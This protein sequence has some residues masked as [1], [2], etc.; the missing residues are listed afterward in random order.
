MKTRYFFLII[1]VAAG[2][3]LSACASSNPPAATQEPQP[4]AVPTEAPTAEP[5]QAPT[6]APEEAPAASADG[7][8]RDDFEQQLDP[9]WTWINEDPS[10]WTIEAGNLQIT[11]ADPPIAPETPEIPMIN[12]LTRPIPQGVD[13]AV[14][15]LLL[16]TNPDENFEQASLLLLDDGDSFV[17]LN[18]GF[19]SFCTQKSIY[20]ETAADG[21]PL[22]EGMQSLP[23]PEDA[24]Q[25]WLRLEYSPEAKVVVATA[26]WD[27]DDFHRVGEIIRD[28]PDFKLAA[29]GAANIPGPESNPDEDLIANFNFFILQ[30]YD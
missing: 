3:C 27:P 1:L 8:F 18:L 5:T 7:P 29:I 2:L 11:A 17:L 22:L 4:T 25:I 15:T 6:R 10:R 20:L 16:N 30:V 23:I 12:L 14:T 21:V 24:T 19:C 9:S 28:V 13:I 26:A